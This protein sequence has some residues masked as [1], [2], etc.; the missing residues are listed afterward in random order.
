MNLRERTLK[1]LFQTL[2]GV[3]KEECEYY[4][5]HFDG[6]DCSFCF[7]PFYPCLIYETGGKFK[8]D[9][10]WSCVDCHYIHKKEIA[11]EIKLEFS[12]YPFQILAEEDWFF[13]NEILQNL[14]FKEVRWKK[15]GKALTLY[16]E[17]SEE[18]YLIKLR[19]FEIERIEKGKLEELSQYE[20][21]LIPK[22]PPS[23]QRQ[24]PAH[25]F[26]R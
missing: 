17:N 14:L 13:F 18:W 26:Q 5:C 19:G 24:A 7:C 4:P 1:E 12:S 11:D 3:E 20:G 15:S 9:K 6:Q 21:I 23:F 10:V 16:D 25:P 8:D 22:Q 2:S